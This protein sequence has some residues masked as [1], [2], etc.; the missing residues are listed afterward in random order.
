MDARND[1]IGET[2]DWTPCSKFYAQGNVN[3]VYNTIN[4]IYPRAGI[5]PATTTA[6]SYDTNNVLQNSLNNNITGSIVLG[7]VL[8]KDDDVQI[9]GN[10]YRAA[11][12][13]AAL[14]PW[15][16][17]YG[18]AIKEQSVTVG[19]KHKFSKTMIGEVK[20]GQFD[21]HND[22]TGGLTN[23]KGT[24]GYVSVTQAF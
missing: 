16:M 20:V 10:Y 5:T 12:G 15:T 4:T 11:N 14:A 7:F 2:I 3:V 19:L 1:T 18:V 23:F 9:Q 21:S 17:P 22:T 6:A 13:N 8:D 24:L